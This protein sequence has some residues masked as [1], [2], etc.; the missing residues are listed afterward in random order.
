[1]PQN[2]PQ[3]PFFV[4]QARIGRRHSAEIERKKIK[5]GARRI[6]SVRRKQRHRQPTAYAQRYLNTKQT[7]FVF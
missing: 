5:S 6:K 2:G 3:G 7:L 1:M 4:G